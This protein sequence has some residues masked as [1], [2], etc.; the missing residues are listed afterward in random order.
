MMQQIS[1]VNQIFP[2]GIWWVSVAT[3]PDP[4]PPHLSHWLPFHPYHWRTGRLLEQELDSAVIRTK[5]DHEAVRETFEPIP[6]PVEVDECALG[7]TVVDLT[8]ESSAFLDNVH[9]RACD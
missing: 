5:A 3:A 6:I 2:K 1:W 8:H 4:L 7:Y 9:R